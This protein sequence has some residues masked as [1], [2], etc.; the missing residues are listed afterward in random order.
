MTHVKLNEPTDKQ[1]MWKWAT[2]A[3]DGEMQAEET[4]QKANVQRDTKAVNTGYKGY[5][6]NKQSTQSNVAKQTLKG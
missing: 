3:C 5:T 4:Q 1:S 6:H 2:C